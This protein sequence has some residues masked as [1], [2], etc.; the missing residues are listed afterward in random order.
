MDQS[1]IW[2]AYRFISS[3]VE[4]RK[5]IITYYPYLN[6]IKAFS[7]LWVRQGE[8]LNFSAKKVIK[9]NYL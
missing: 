3:L 7:P 4:R 9:V 1:N 6:N 2:L 8:A 5:S